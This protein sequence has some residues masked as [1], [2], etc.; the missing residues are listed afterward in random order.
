ML[1]SARTVPHGETIRTDVCII[2]G[3]PAGIT[4]ARELASAQLDIVLLERGDAERVQT[5]D[6]ADSIINVGLPYPVEDTRALALGGSVHKWRVN[7]PDGGGFGRLRELD[8]EDFDRRA[9]VAHSGWP[10]GKDELRR[11][12][13]TARQLFDPRWEAD[14]PEEDLEARLRPGPFEAE[15]PNVK[16]RVFYFAD[17]S[18]FASRHKRRLEQAANVLVLT[19][20]AA[21]EIC[22]DGLASSISSVRVASSPSCRFSIIARV[23]VICAGAIETARLLLASRSRFPT[24]LGNGYDLV[25]RYFM[26]H[27]HYFAGFFRPNCPES[28][29]VVENYA[30][31]RQDGHLIQRKFTLGEKSLEQDALL[32]SAFMLNAEPR[33]EQVHK[34]GLSAQAESRLDSLRRLRRKLASDGP[35]S[36]EAADLRLA[37]M[38]APQAARHGITKART[39][40]GRRLGLS[41]YTSPSIFRI[42]AM[43]EQIPNPSSRVSLADSTDGLDMPRAKLSWQLTEQDKRSMRLS[44]E[45]FGRALESRG[46]RKVTSLLENRDLPAVLNGGSHHMGT[47]R[48]HDSPRNG[49]VDR[50]ARVHATDNLYVAGAAVFPT[51]G[52][53]N[54]TLTLLALTLRLAAHLRAEFA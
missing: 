52:Y 48:M 38:G 21:T 6:E 26:E 47:T 17:P 2:G 50:N 49:V 10:F 19:N 27:P 40:A 4:L 37:I 44:Q 43:H 24:G 18:A 31:H 12:Y 34:L 9:W 36:V 16:S 5:V 11:H 22:S 28:L 3:G 7:T 25:G 32:R 33:T 35:T 14:S 51:V 1:T 30:P 29:Q 13:R 8:P 46:H 42:S 39:A 45:L 20:A 53:A 41:Q 54:P 23:Y 15:D